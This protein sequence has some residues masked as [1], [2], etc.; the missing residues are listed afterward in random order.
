MAEARPNVHRRRFGSALRSLRRNAGLGMEE[1]AE[2]LG[3]SGKPA[4]SKIENGKQRVS[5]LGLTAFFQVYEVPEDVRAKVKAMAVLAASGKR[6]NLIDEFREAIQTDEFEEYLNLEG[7]A[8]KTES[9]LTVVPG[10][11]QTREYAASIVE[12]SQ[13][14]S[15]KREANRFVELR[16]AR[17]AALTRE[18]PLNLWCIL[19]EA[20]LRR[21]V[22]GPEVMKAQLERLL[23]VSEEYTH[24]AIQVLPFSAGA[25]AGIDG[26]F[27]L[28]H[29]PA[30]PPVA[31]VETKT[32]SLYLE[33]DGDVD[34]Y[35]SALDTLRTQA[36]DEQATRRF[37]RELIK[38]CY[39]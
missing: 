36:L 29:F 5:G 15:S 34:R 1:A 14:W 2:R 6:T 31:L 4:L 18:T 39:T 33:E 37:I 12:R 26:P 19:D 35:R 28:L 27:Q 30:G 7:M 13:V 38:D 3:L 10:L 24:V 8:S 11:L 17:Q 32:T 16:M 9:L 25:H 20:A 21:V 23:E 22:G